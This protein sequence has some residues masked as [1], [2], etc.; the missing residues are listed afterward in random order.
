MIKGTIKTIDKGA[1]A[2]EKTKNAIISIKEKGENAYNSDDSVNEYTSN[3][4]NQTSIRAINDGISKFNSKGRKSARETK[5]NFKKAKTKIKTIKS[6]LSEKRKV[7]KLKKNIK[8]AKKAIKTTKKVATETIKT[9]DR[10]R[11]LAMETAKKT[12]QVLKVTIKVTISTVKAIIAGAKALISAIIAGGWVAVIIVVVILLIA[13]ILCSDFGIFFS[14]DNSNII[15]MDTVINDI[16]NELSNKINMIKNSNIYDEYKINYNPLSWKEILAVYTIKVSDEENT[17]TV[18]LNTN[19][20][21][22]LKDIYWNVN[23]VTHQMNIE[24]GKNLLVINVSSKTLEETMNLYSFSEEQ[25]ERVNILLSSEYS[26]MWNSVILGTYDTNFLCPVS[27]N[28]SITTL[29]STEHQAID[30]SSYFGDNIYSI[31]DG[32][33]IVSK[34]GCIVGDLECNGKAGNYVVIQHRDIGYFSSYMHLDSVYV[35]VGDKVTIG[36]VIGTMGNTGNVV[37]VP[38]EQNSKLGTHLHFVLQKGREYNSS[39]PVNPI[40]LFIN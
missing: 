28:F 3:K 1:V 24:E 34:L 27:S 5:D 12:Y 13:L 33:V 31:S 29:Y 4:V 16:D 6:K 11:K 18:T 40:N 19:K 36:D 9:A 15:T 39:S 25:K 26:D 38:T 14:S 32:T 37:P 10:A 20:I 30:V 7:K 17:D 21:S 23:L 22:Y 35:S 8:N 2:I